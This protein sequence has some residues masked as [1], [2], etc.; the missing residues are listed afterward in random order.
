MNVLYA[1]L[2]VFAIVLALS[3][4][5]WLSRK[6]YDWLAPQ[7]GKLLALGSIVALWFVGVVVKA[8]VARA[9]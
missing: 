9:F 1:F 5:L 7:I 4:A 8:L 3:F 6:L 2:Y